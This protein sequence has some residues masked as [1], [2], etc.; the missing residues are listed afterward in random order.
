MPS[1]RRHCHAPLAIERQV[2]EVEHEPFAVA[3]GRHP[4]LRERLV[5]TLDLQPASRYTWKELT[6]AYNQTRIDYIVPMPMNVER[7]REYVHDYDVNLDASVVA[8]E[9]DQI[10][11][12]AM[13]GVRPRHTWATRLGVLPITRQRGLGQ[14]LMEYLLHQSCCLGA[15]HVVLEAIRGN[16]P[17][18]HL[19][20]RL[21]FRDTRELLILR[22]PPGRP[23]NQGCPYV[24]SQILGHFESLEQLRGR[25]DV[26]SWLDE[27]PSLTNTDSLT[28]LRVE[29]GNGQRGWIVYRN[30]IFQLSHL[31]LQTETGDPRQVGQALLHA[32]HARHPA[33][34]TNTENIPAND[35]HLPALRDL[36]YL[37][38]F[39]RIEMRLDLPKGDGNG[40]SNAKPLS[41]P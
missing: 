29:L 17:A 20:R 5:P 40:S 11:G 23:S 16:E 13:L 27:T 39:R 9:D 15:D 30:R 18:Y 28:G 7:L 36:H 33:Q 21:G 35:P 31:V 14:S 8:A 1:S 4:E 37:E 24:V 41:P 19:F 10:I 38:S 32:L 25:N 6:D 2:I 22:R 26:P 34:D 12:L 3:P